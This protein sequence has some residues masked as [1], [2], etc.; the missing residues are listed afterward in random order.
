MRDTVFDKYSITPNQKIIEGEIKD[1]VFDL[2][3]DTDIKLVDPSELITKK[4]IF[5]KTT[6]TFKTG[7]VLLKK[8]KHTKIVNPSGFII[9]DEDD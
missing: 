4:S 8:R 5:G 1:Y 9:Y 6:T 3:N 2:Y 7:W